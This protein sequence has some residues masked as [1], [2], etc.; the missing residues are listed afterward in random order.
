MPGNLH[1]TPDK[2]IWHVPRGSFR[3]ER[4]PTPPPERRLS[5]RCS[6]QRTRERL[7]DDAGEHGAT[8]L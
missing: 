3:F 5:A 1:C 6:G 4:D 2:V 8:M 7:G